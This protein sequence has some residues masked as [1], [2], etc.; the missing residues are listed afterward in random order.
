MKHTTASTFVGLFTLFTVLSIHAA[1]ITWTNTMAGYWSVAANWNPNRVP[2]AADTAVLPI[3]ASNGAALDATI[4]VQNLV[5]N[6]G[7][8]YN[9]GYSYDT[10]TVNGELDWTNGILGC[11]ITN[12]G[13]ITLAGTNGV[14][15]SL[16]AYLYNA[17]A[18]NIISGNL[19][20]N[21][22]G[23]NS[24]SLDNAPGALVNI[25]NDANIDI[26][27]NQFGFCNPP[28]SNEGII[29]KSGGSGT[30]SLYPALNNS[31]AVDA[32]TGVI[33]FNGGGTLDGT[34]QSEGNG[35]LVLA[36]N[37]YN[38]VLVL[39]GNLSSPNAFLEGANL[40]GV[41]TINGTLTWIAGSFAAGSSG[42]TIG[43]NG[44]MILAGTNG[45]DYS[46][47]VALYNNGTF[48]LVSGNLLI[49]YCGSAFGEFFNEPGGLVDFQNDVSI[50]ASCGGQLINRGI[51]RKSGDL[52]TSDIGAPFDN[53][54]GTLDAQF[55]TIAL[56]NS[57]NLAGG[58]L[59]IGIGSPTSYGQVYLAGNP[60]LTGALS[61]NINGGPLTNGNAFPVVTYASASGAFSPV[62][63]PP[64]INW[65][66]NYGPTALTLTVVNLEGQPVLEPAALPGAVQLFGLEFTGNP[67]ATYSILATTNLIVPLT[68]WTVLGS[69]ILVS[70][71]LFEFVDTQTKNYP[72]RFY[73]LSS[74]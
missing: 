40:A 52:G 22:C 42:L 7:N 74:H 21:Y 70:N 47:N 25:E 68:N 30:T 73:R 2:G 28:F 71:D 8:L 66:T 31:G 46:L 62:T 54:G 45:G 9:T 13:V 11:E 37:I 24:G 1:A 39:D 18:F 4:T 23:N 72:Q 67:N 17:G 41:G 44:V 26:S 53:T 59:N 6:G 10:L 15:Y 56:T 5:L 35:A 20:I 12:N 50:V 51:V 3:A 29:R 69:A 34:L 48:K 19:L 38:T 27:S 58:A 55:G 36:S 33:S 32:Q 63:L 65:Q 14:D 16:T 60:A 61:V 57:Y 49:N 64:W 43:T